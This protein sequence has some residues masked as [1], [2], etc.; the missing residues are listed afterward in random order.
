MSPIPRPFWQL[1]GG[2]AVAHIALIPAGL[3]LQRGPLFSDGTQ[4]I[5][6]F[7]VEGDL[8]RSLAGGI[9][10]AYGFLLMFPVLVFL[11]RTLGRSTEG[12]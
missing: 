9:P 6:E 2:L 8:T 1:A 10:E 3:F 12:G 7:Y 11:G 4:G 5:E